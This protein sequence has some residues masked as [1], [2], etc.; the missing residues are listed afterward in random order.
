M[1]RD[2]VSSNGDSHTAELQQGLCVAGVSLSP[3]LYEVSARACHHLLKL[4][5]CAVAAF[6]NPLLLGC[7][8]HTAQLLGNPAALLS[9]LLLLSQPS[10]F[11]G[12]SSE[13][14]IKKKK[15]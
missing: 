9:V 13:Q 15:Q 10:A 4:P 3:L 7:T 6:S 5:L 8:Q 14:I 2:A 11:N 1:A 12:K